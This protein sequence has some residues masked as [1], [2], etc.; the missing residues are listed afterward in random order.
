MLTITR[1]WSFWPALVVGVGLGATVGLVLGVLTLRMG[2]HYFAIGSLAFGVM[3]QLVIKKLTS[4][5][6]G[7]LGLSPVPPITPITLPGGHQIEFT[8]LTARYGIAYA[9]FVTAVAL[10]VLLRRS[11]RGRGLAAIRQNPR[12]AEA[13]GISVVRMRLVALVT[14]GAIA[15][16]AGALYATFVIFIEPSVASTNLNIQAGIALDHRRGGDDPRPGRGRDHARRPAGAPARRPEPRTGAPRHRA[17]RH[18][19]LRARGIVGEFG[20]LAG[21]VRLRRGH[22]GG[23]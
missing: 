1:G 23:R 11:R 10:M 14:S 12:L 8:S 6:G 7:E 9:F 13:V 15:G 3:I 20:R 21:H 19:P 22:A 4:V 2:G 16:A 17:A 18:H 5:T